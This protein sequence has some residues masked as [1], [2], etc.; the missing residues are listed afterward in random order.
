MRKILFFIVIIILIF[1]LLN[2][3]K[4]EAR[5]FFYSFSAPIQKFFWRIGE[6]SSNFLSAIFKATDLKKEKD[7]LEFENQELIIRVAELNKLKEE[8]KSLKQALNLELDKDFKLAF[9][10]II[11][12]DISQDFILINKGNQDGILENMPVITEQKVLIG[13]ISETYK[14]FSKVMLISHK[15]SSFDAKILNQEQ[16]SGVIRGLGNFNLLFDFISLENEV[17]PGDIILTS[18]LGGIFPENLL[19]G[20]VKKVKKSDL[21]SFQQAEIEPIFNISKSSNVFIILEF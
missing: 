14:N 21:E 7:E 5:S 3:F 1:S 12:K 2:F 9:A 10:Q 4:K 15:E 16:C 13:R 19:V 18:C 17:H 6:K 20:E 11:S 8:N